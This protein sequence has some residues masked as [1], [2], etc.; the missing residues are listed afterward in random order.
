VA[1]SSPTSADEYTYLSPLFDELADESLPESDR[2]HVRARLI[3][4]HLPV[5]EHI[6]RRFRNKGQPEEDLRQVATVG[7]IQAVDRF[8]AG[9]GT[10]FLA[11]AV[12]TITGEIRKYFRDRTWAVRVPRRLKELNAAVTEA[13]TRLGQELGRAARP[14]ELAADLGI[15]ID[16]VT[17]GLQVGYAYRNDSLDNTADHDGQAVAKTLGAIDPEMATVENQ[18]VLYPALARLP[19]REATIVTLRFF[20]HQTQTQI[21]DR[22]GISQMHVS[23]LLTSSLRTLRDFLREDTDG[24]S[25]A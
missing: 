7:L 14:S 11:F 4:G 19:K 6:A 18:A 12:P 15:S 1:S 25:F 2:E 5:A 3:T 24:Q 16:D 9:R 20:G 23:R 13:A 17:E 8:E 10:D 22:L 21:A